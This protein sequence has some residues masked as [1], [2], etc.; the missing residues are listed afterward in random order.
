M[1]NKKTI[2]RMLQLQDVREIFKNRNDGKS[3]KGNATQGLHRRSP[4]LVLLSPSTLKF[5]VSM[6]SG[7]L[8]LV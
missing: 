2:I 5:G 8:V 4:I 6:G 1:E 3:K 7:A